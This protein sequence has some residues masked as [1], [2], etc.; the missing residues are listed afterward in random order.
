MSQP[1]LL[2]HDNKIIDALML[3]NSEISDLLKPIDADITQASQLDMVGVEAVC[4][5]IGSGHSIKAVCKQLGVSVKVFMHWQAKLSPEDQSTIDD[6]KII[7]LESLESVCQLK[8][9]DIAK[10]GE[11]L[12]EEDESTRDRLDL[13]NRAIHNLERVIKSV[14][15]TLTRLQAKQALRENTEAEVH[16][17]QM[18]VS[19]EWLAA[20]PDE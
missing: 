10:I 1:D 12:N 13:R 17:T 19:N 2:L 18:I 8:I 5:A 6:A 20:L 3:P 14:Q 16:I 7:W 11:D 15:A 9:V 4:E